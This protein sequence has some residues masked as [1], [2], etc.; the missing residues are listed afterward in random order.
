[1]GPTNINIMSSATSQHEPARIPVPWRLVPDSLPSIEAV[2]ESNVVPPIRLQVVDPF[3]PRRV[4]TLEYIDHGKGLG[5]TGLVDTDIVKITLIAPFGPHTSLFQLVEMS[6]VN[7]S[8]RTFYSSP[9]M[10]VVHSDK[11][12][13]NDLAC[14]LRHDRTDVH[15][16]LHQLML[17]MHMGCVVSLKLIRDRNANHIWSDKVPVTV[18]FPSVDHGTGRLVFSSSEAKEA[19]HGKLKVIIPEGGSQEWLCPDIHSLDQ[20]DLKDIEC[21]RLFAERTEFVLNRAGP[22]QL[23]VV[24]R[25]CNF[26]TYKVPSASMLLGWLVRTGRFVLCA[27]TPDQP[28]DLFYLAVPNPEKDQFVMPLIH[29]E[30]DCD[31]KWCLDRIQSARFPPSEW[32]YVEPSKFYHKS[33][34]ECQDFTKVTGQ[35]TGYLALSRAQ[36]EPDGHLVWY[37]SDEKMTESER[38][39]IPEGSALAN[40]LKNLRELG[41]Q[42]PTLSVHLSLSDVFN[43]NP[44][45]SAEYWKFMYYSYAKLLATDYL[46]GERQFDLST[47]RDS[48]RWSLSKLLGFDGEI[49]FVCPER[50][51]LFP[52]ILAAGDMVQWN[53]GLTNAK[54]NFVELTVHSIE[55]MRQRCVGLLVAPPDDKGLRSLYLIH[56]F[57]GDGFRWTGATDLNVVSDSHGKLLADL[58]PFYSLFIDREPLHLNDGS[59]VFRFAPKN[60]N[61]LTLFTRL[62]VPNMTRWLY[63]CPST[64]QVVRVDVTSPSK[65]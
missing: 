41:T 7:I 48:C 20:I 33:T 19:F 17:T 30:M 23:F 44:K 34:G 40:D 63:D 57:L 60:W 4:V 8:S 16:A 59:V 49:P 13:P 65:Q 12:A 56:K 14:L 25:R 9:Q 18:P 24:E 35:V 11:D 36:L 50:N 32:I 46:N 64:R 5:I 61:I 29:P 3:D 51:C 39:K 6:N 43:P 21:I 31:Q 47:L 10:E 37:S 22:T 53:S 2:C 1:M 62:G 38:I 15:Q 55:T 42:M 54:E 27:V 52:L 28:D 58:V 26:A 45:E